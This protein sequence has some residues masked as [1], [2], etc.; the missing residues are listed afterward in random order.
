MG[1]IGGSELNNADL[2][3]AW[4][5]WAELRQA[6]CDE[7]TIWPRISPKQGALIAPAAPRTVTQPRLKPVVH[8][9]DVHAGADV[10][11]EPVSSAAA[12]GLWRFLLLS[13]PYGGSTGWW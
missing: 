8:A 1:S 6:R 7:T 11:Q 4:L 9:G 5:S 13:T 12:S 2:S 3:R 10:M